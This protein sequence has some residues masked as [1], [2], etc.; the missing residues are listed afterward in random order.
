VIAKPDVFTIN[1]HGSSDLSNTCHQWLFYG[2]ARNDERCMAFIMVSAHFAMDRANA[3]FQYKRAFSDPVKASVCD[4]ATN[5]WVTSKRQF[6]NWHEYAHTS[7]VCAI[8][9]RAKKDCLRQ[10][11]FPGDCLH[12]RIGKVF[13]I[14]HHR[15]R[16][17]RQSPAGENIKYAVADFTHLALPFEVWTIINLYFAVL[18]LNYQSNFVM[19]L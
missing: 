12:L 18:G 9:W 10:V 15:K 5:G 13:R 6:A 2:Q 17:A 19:H 14:H 3:F 8:F 16:I 1:A 4:G 11:E 7:C